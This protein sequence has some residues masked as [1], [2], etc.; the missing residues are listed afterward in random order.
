MANVT[1][2]DGAKIL[3]LKDINGKKPEIYIITSNRT[4][5]KSTFFARMEIKRF[6]RDKKKFMYN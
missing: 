1:H 4:D 5:G 3:S 2:Y 6:K